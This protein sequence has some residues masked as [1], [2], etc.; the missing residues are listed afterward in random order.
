[1]KG[2]VVYIHTRQDNRKVFY[3]GIGSTR[4]RAYDE[5]SRSS[6]WKNVL[7]ETF[8]DVSIVAEGLS[9]QEAELMEERLIEAIGLDQLKNKTAGGSGALGYNHTDETKKLLSEYQKG[10]K[11]SKEEIQKSVKSRVEAYSRLVIHRET[12]EII[13]GL[14]FACD[15]YD[16]PYRAEHQR[17][18]RESFNRTFDYYEGDYDKI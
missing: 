7:K 10:R 14:K 12:K 5:H 6:D 15:K 4:G 17:L 18:R 1:M 16:I 11:K 3:V 8:F 13:R 9:K 2:Y